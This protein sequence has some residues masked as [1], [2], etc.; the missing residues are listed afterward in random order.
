L[1]EALSCGVPAV[2]NNVGAVADIMASEPNL[3]LT[4][5]INALPD[6]KKSEEIAL[7]IIHSLT[8][9]H[10]RERQSKRMSKYTWDWCAKEHLKALRKATY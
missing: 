7:A 6:D 9:Q 1:T 4:I 2:A 8:H 5:N 10:D 3:G